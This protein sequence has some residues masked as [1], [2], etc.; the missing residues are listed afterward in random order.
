PVTN[1]LIRHTLH[2][3][4]GGQGAVKA[5]LLTTAAGGNKAATHLPSAPR[6]QHPE[7]LTSGFPPDYFQQHGDSWPGL[8]EEKIP[9]WLTFLRA[10]S[11]AACPSH[12]VS[13]GMSAP[14]AEASVG[15]T[16]LA[17]PMGTF[18]S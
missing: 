18:P 4:A 5:G 6:A 13:K 8:R 3:A 15:R 11:E 17:L 1:V 2:R 7:I 16:D 9:L 10:A 12:P 14:P